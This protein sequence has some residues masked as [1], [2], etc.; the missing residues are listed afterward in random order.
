MTGL[1]YN[2]AASRLGKAPRRIPPK[3]EAGRKPNVL[4]SKRDKSVV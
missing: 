3:Y 1:L 4:V 2:P